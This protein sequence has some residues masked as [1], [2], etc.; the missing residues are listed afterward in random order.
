[1]EVYEFLP[2]WAN[3]AENALR[4]RLVLLFVGVFDTQDDEDVKKM[5]LTAVKWI[6]AFQALAVAYDVCEVHCGSGASVL[7]VLICALCCRSGT[8]QLLMRICA[9][10]WRLRTP[11]RG[12]TRKLTTSCVVELGT[13]G[14]SVVRAAQL[15]C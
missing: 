13:R 14:Q 3:P 1:M 6:G 10:A 12:R 8:T 2:S 7:F 9:R 5:Q 4:V 15:V 11:P